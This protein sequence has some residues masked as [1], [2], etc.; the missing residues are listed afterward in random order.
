MPV[1][2][3]PSLTPSPTLNQTSHKEIE[4]LKTMPG[5][6]YHADGFEVRIRISQKRI[7]EFRKSLRGRN[8]EKML[9]ILDQGH[10]WWQV[11][12]RGDGTCPVTRLPGIF[13][14]AHLNWL[15][16]LNQQTLT[17]VN[18]QSAANKVVVLKS[19]A[20]RELRLLPASQ[21]VLA[22]KSPPQLSENKLA[23]LQARFR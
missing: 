12:V 20:L 6:A 10:G 11:T 7:T 23:M 9:D 2:V 19:N 1:I 4:M 17:A 21:Q 16:E 14:R 13:S 3:I 22:P 8:F 15:A 5:Y 18:E